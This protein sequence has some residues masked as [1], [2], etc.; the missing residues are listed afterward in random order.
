MVGGVQCEES[1]ARQTSCGELGTGCEAKHTKCGELGAGCGE[2]SEV[3]GDQGEACGVRSTR[4]TVHCSLLR[5]APL[6]LKGSYRIPECGGFFCGSIDK[7]FGTGIMKQY[8]V[9]AMDEHMEREMEE[10]RGQ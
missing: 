3:C 7:W 8:V 9:Q 4:N 5:Y 1:G 10:E 6:H 2:G